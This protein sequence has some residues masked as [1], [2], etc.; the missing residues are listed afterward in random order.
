A[1]IL[2]YSSPA[3]PDSYIDNDEG[4]KSFELLRKS[5]NGVTSHRNL[6]S[7]VI[8]SYSNK[9][10]RYNTL[11]DNILK[12]VISVIRRLKLGS[13]KIPHILDNIE[14]KYAKRKSASN[15]RI[16]TNLSVASSSKAPNNDKLSNDQFLET[17]LQI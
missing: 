12:T 5:Y 3:A 2:I 4:R 7:N 16:R 9:Y 13:N 6:D 14:E 1:P 8:V 17:A 10:S 15:K 11:K